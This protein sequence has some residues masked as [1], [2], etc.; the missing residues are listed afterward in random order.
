VLFAFHAFELYVIERNAAAGDEFI[1]VE[2][3]PIYGKFRLNQLLCESL[4]L[5]FCDLG[6]SRGIDDSGGFAHSL[7]EPLANAVDGAALAHFPNA[8]SA[9]MLVEYFLH[10]FKAFAS[11]PVDCH[12]EPVIGIG[13]VTGAPGGYFEDG[14][15]TQ[16]PMGDQQGAFALVAVGRGGGMGNG[17]S[18][19]A[20]NPCIV[21]FESKQRGDG[22]TKLVVEVFC[23]N[24]GVFAA[25]SAR[26][27]EDISSDE[28]ISV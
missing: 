6:P 16:S 26:C 25:D 11:S 21:N 4:T 10:G 13:E 19:Q 9:T 15:T 12:G 14:G 8:M 20:V 28:M 27:D 17:D 5:E 22:R 7:P 1:L 24:S 2:A 3:F 23:W 18:L